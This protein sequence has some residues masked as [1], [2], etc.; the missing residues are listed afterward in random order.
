V[1]S[2]VSET[3]IRRFHPLADS[4]VRLVCFPHAGGAAS[5]YYPLSAALQEHVEVLCVQ[6]PGRH[7]RLREPLI[8]DIAGL[9]DGVTEA[10]EAWRGEPL[11]FFGHS[12]GAVVA[13]EVARRLA[14]SGAPGPVRLFASGRRAP[15]AYRNDNVHKGG[16]AALLADIRALDGTAAALLAD[17]DMLRMALPVLRNDYRAVETYRC[18]PGPPLDCPVTVL[19]GDTDPRVTEEEAHAWDEHTAGGFEVRTFAGGHFYLTAH[20][21]GISGLVRDRLDA[22]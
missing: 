13:F 6:Y 8:G 15:S 14:D 12:M 7:E 2:A 4:P 5:F 1:T 11:A 3:W 20:W 9:A 18:L 16:D 22:E 21:S 17:E 10:L 19:T